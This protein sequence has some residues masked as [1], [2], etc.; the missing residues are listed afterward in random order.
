M[1]HLSVCTI[2]VRKVLVAV[3]FLAFFSNRRE[4]AK[5][6]I[7]LILVAFELDFGFGA[8]VANV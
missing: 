3:Q 6:S 5:G 2:D 4:I 7:Q 8:T 1:Y